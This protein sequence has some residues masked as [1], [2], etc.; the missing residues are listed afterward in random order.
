VGLWLGIPGGVIAVL[1]IACSLV[2]IAPGVVV[3]GVDIG[4]RMPGYATEVVQKA[5]ADTVVTIDTPSKDVSLTGEELGLTVDAQA[6]AALAY[7]EYPIWKVN[8]WNP[9]DIPIDVNVDAAAALDA[10]ADVAPSVFPAPVDAGVT[11][12]TKLSE[13][14]ATDAE[15][16]MGIDFDE[17]ADAVSVALSSGSRTVTVTSEPEPVPAAISTSAAEKQATELNEL[18]ETAGF[19]IDDKKVVGFDRADAASW[20]TVTPVDGQLQV[21]VDRNAAMAIVSKVVAD[22][23]KTVNHAAVNEIIVTNS[24]GDHLRTVQEGVDGYKLGST[25][26]VAGDFITLFSEGNGVYDLTVTDVPFETALAF[27][28]IEVNKTTG[29]TILYENGKVVDTFPVAVGRPATPTPEGHFT[30]FWQLPLQDMGCVPGYDYCTKD[31]PWVS[32]FAGDNGFHGTYWHDNFGAGA[33][34]SHGCV[35]MQIA[36]AE[37]VYYFA[38]LG[39]EVW[40]HS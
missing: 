13:F 35:N 22:L 19:Y 3:A 39:T 26:G 2:L 11:F 37:R 21:E 10:L 34:M 28:S 36:A 17:L 20:I 23:P 4:W 8:A 27:R 32:Y 24:A 16:G 15:P 30:V 38:Q 6:I 29:Q 18:I 1:A 31:V 33:M 7:G 25:S 5:L 14:E 9:G 12:D 40:V